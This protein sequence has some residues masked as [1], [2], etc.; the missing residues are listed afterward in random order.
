MERVVGP[1]EAD[2]GWQSDPWRT[3]EFRYFAGGEATRWVCSAGVITEELVVSLD[4]LGLGTRE[5]AVGPADL[6]PIDL[7]ANT[8]T[9]GWREDP[10]H[11]HEF[12]YFAGGGATRWVSSV[13]LISEELVVSI[14]ELLDALAAEA[15]AAQAR[16]DRAVKHF[17]EVLA[18]AHNPNPIT[19]WPDRE[20]MTTPGR[21]IVHQP[22]DSLAPPPSSGSASP[23]AA[24]RAPRRKTSRRAI[25]AAV[26]GALVVT[27]S[28]VALAATR[29]GRAPAPKTSSHAAAPAPAEPTTP[30]ATTLA[31]GTGQLEAW[32]TGSAQP[33]I[34]A[35]VADI[36]QL[37]NLAGSPADLPNACRI[38]ESDAAA[39]VALPPAPTAS[40]E[41]EWQQTLATVNRVAN[42]CASGRY[43]QMAGDLQPASFTIHDL[44]AQVTSQANGG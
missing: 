8:L 24:T 37:T 28:L 22:G 23:E 19:A 21:G 16:V 26:V 27:G 14:A 40:V 20:P 42:A 13:G 7:A 11:T 31:T 29:G 41:R 32:W 39:A 6:E 44:T 25:V 12:R 10:W 18:G 43:T 38:F 34:R 2:H 35:L 17:Q 3:H 1:M 4:E 9:D 30:T 15:A 5:T 33:E 36:E